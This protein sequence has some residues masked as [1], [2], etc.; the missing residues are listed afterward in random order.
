M[1]KITNQDLFGD[2]GNIFG[3][4]T[5]SA[6]ALIKVLDQLETQL[7]D[8]VKVNA[9]LAAQTPAKGYENINNKAKAI[10]NV[11]NATDGLDKIEKERIRLEE[12]LTQL[13]STEIQ[14]NTQLK[15][16]I[17]EQTK[18]NK[19]LAREKLGLVSVYEKESRRLNDLRKRY[20][21]SALTLG[22]S[23][24]ETKRLRREAEQLDSRLKRIDGNVGQFQRNVGNYASAFRNLSGIL[25]AAGITLGAAGF[26]RVLR[27]GVTIVRDFQKENAVLA[28]VLNTTRANI[29]E[30]TDDAVRL[31]RTTVKTAQEVTQLQLAYSRLGFSQAEIL[32]LTEPT[33]NGSIAL[34]AAL[35]ETAELTG[36]VVR[37]FDAFGTSDAPEIL[38]KLTASTQNSALTFSKLQTALPTVAGAANAAGISFDRLLALLGKLSDAGIDASVSS[39]ALRNIFIESAKQGLSYEQILQKITN[40]Q[41]KLTAAN[42]EFG[43]RAAVSATVLANNIA[44]TGELEEKIGQA[45]GTAERVAKEQLAT[46]DGAVQLLRSAWEG[47]VISLN[48]GDRI[49]SKIS[50]ALRFLA[51]NLATIIRVIAGAAAGFIAYKTALIVSNLATKAYNAITTIA[52][53]VTK[54]FNA[55]LKANPLALVASLIGVVVSALVI[56]KGKTEEATEANDEYNESLKETERL[57]NQRKINNFLRQI[58]IIKTELRDLGNGLKEQVDVIDLSVESIEK[59][60]QGVKNLT[61]SEINALKAVIQSEILELERLGTKLPKGIVFDLTENQ[62]QLQTLQNTLGVLN[63]ELAKIEKIKTANDKVDN[64]NVES[65]KKLN[66]ELAELK[67]KRDALAVTDLQGIRNANVD[68]LLPERRIQLIKEQTAVIDD[69]IEKKKEADDI[70]PARDAFSEL[71]SLED[72]IRAAEEK[73]NKERIERQETV[74]ASLDQIAQNSFAK[75]LKLIDDEIAA[76]KRRQ[77]V[78]AQLTEQGTDQ[79]LKTLAFE[80]KKQAELEQQRQRE[81]QR[82]KRAELGL[83]ALKTYGQKVDQGVDNPLVSTFR[84]ISLLQA[85]INS[86]PAFEAGTEGKTVGEVLGNPDMPGKDGYIVRVDR[87]EII[88]NQHEAE[89]YNKLMTSSLYSFNPKKET[90]DQLI[91]KIIVNKLDAIK[92]EVANKP[93][94]MGR[95]YNATERAIIDT[96]I[97]KNKIERNHKKT[98]GIW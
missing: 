57:L 48:E 51:E 70:G 58:G 82:Q 55:A 75:R 26:F 19:Q 54:G 17:Q 83:Q 49:T 10:N 93:V 76:N 90:T 68:I 56:F 6:Q 16:Q 92:N 66:E 29:K 98:G 80:Q 24:K 11:K 28:G 33:I 39:T 3:K 40:E 44:A 25:S 60:I 67:K 53:A 8:I 27:N 12:K 69:L 21:D 31:G 50:A 81:L 85:F 78:L 32:D 59:L 30:L 71:E 77:D 41:D 4:T 62:K 18:L 20:K 13:Q 87:D 2:Q 89:D 9:E 47:Y 15:V 36:A 84:D 35:D 79:A 74:F 7:K 52:T 86:L 96:I 95:D 1:A 34:N 43:K 94:Y 88:L 61:E 72:Q 73:A 97:S 23:A 42:D 46:L 45:G 91:N 37:T 65:L 64:D 22:E 38:D 63:Q 5:E 14:K